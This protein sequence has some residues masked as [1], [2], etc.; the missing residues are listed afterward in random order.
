MRRRDRRRFGLVLLGALAGVACSKP[1]PPTITSARPSAISVN[2]TGLTVRL[3]LGMKNDNG[4]VI[5]VQSVRAHVVLGDSIDL[6]TATVTEAVPLA[7]HR[8]T[9]VPVSVDMAWS[10]MGQLGQLALSPHDV[11]YTADGAVI[12]GGSMLNVTVPFAM[13]GAI[14]QQDL[15]RG[16]LQGL[17][18]LMGK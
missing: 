11:K 2:P 15:T 12:L 14:T 6:G 10:N 16:A 17:P 9:M 13:T 4:V 1:Q 7:A 18:L 3:E 5:P 8:E